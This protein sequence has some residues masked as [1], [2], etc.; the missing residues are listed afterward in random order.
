LF[1]T[2]VV[3]RPGCSTAGWATLPRLESALSTSRI[4]CAT[5]GVFD[6]TARLT[7]TTTH[8]GHES[9]ELV[10]GGVA[11]ATLGTIATDAVV[12]APRLANLAIGTI[13]SHM[14]SLTTD[15]ADDAGREVLLL[16]AVVLAMTDLTTVLAG[17]VFVISKGTVEGGKLTELVALEFVLAFGNRGSLDKISMRIEQWG[18]ISTY[19]LNDVVN[20][21]LGLVDL[22]LSVGHDQAMQVFLLVAGVS[23]V[24]TAFTLLDGA[25]ATDRNLCAGFGFHLL[26]RVSTRANKETNC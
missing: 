12:V 17:L 13:A 20:E 22:L 23:G 10:L 1:A 6:S 19:G 18:R 15:A 9:I 21:L 3:A 11:D 26:E 24:R 16:G 7:A 2:I 5:V 14:S 25:F 4:V 8:L